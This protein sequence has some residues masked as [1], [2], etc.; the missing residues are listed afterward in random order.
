MPDG[1]ASPPPSLPLQASSGTTGE[2]PQGDPLR[3]VI[4]KLNQV[5]SQGQ[6]ALADPALARTV[7]KLVEQSNDPGHLEHG[8]F[9]T[10]VAYAVQD[11]EKLPT[12]SVTMPAAL[13][14]EMTELAATSPGLQNERMQALVA[15]TPE[16]TER[17]LIED[18]RRA[19]HQ[20]ARSGPEQDTPE[21]RTRIEALEAR[22]GITPAAPSVTSNEPPPHP[23]PDK[24]ASAG[25]DRPTGETPTTTQPQPAK[26]ESGSPAKAADAPSS[27]EKVIATP[28]PGSGQTVVAPPAE[29]TAPAAKA[30]SEP[31]A[32]TIGASK[33]PEASVTQSQSAGKVVVGAG[34]TSAEQLAEAAGVL[35]GAATSIAQ[36]ASAAAKAPAQPRRQTVGESILTSMRKPQPTTPP[37]W[38]AAQPPVG[39]RLAQM[40]QQVGDNRMERLVQAAEK[41]GVSLNAALDQFTTGPGRGVMARLES[42]AAKDPGGMPAVIAGMKPD[43]PYAAERAEFNA[44]LRDPAIAGPYNVVTSQAAKHAE[45]RVA[46]EDTLRKRGL[47]PTVLGDRLEKKDAELADKA[48][49][50]PGRESGKNALEEMAQKL[51]ELLQKAMEKVGQVIDRA[52]G[53]GV[54]AQTRPGP[55]PSPG[56]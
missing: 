31:A 14:A 16:L 5:V 6:L 36:A 30:A 18:I 28:S 20:T 53:A 2:A 19:A 40:E 8:S 39:P 15:K 13:R 4:A 38:S 33:A 24:V 42:A 56:M 51:A 55:S 10:G 50:I 46:V 26:P 45:A 32:Q 52:A 21:L 47:D 43:G 25:P 37:P 7:G 12:I 34:Q 3:D 35:A 17:G 9:R 48:A 27:E 1:S 29:P 49:S 11:L 23:G 22:A 54:Q 44:A 41:S